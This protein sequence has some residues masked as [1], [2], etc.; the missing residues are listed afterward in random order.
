MS[1]AAMLYLA[2]VALGLGLILG[3]HGEPKTGKYS[4]WLQLAA[5][6]IPCGLLYWGGFFARVPA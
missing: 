3:K 6:A 4:F 1:A 5:S 2:L